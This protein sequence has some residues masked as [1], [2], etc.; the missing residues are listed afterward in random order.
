MVM[1]NGCLCHHFPLLLGEGLEARS[2]RGELLRAF[3]R[4]LQEQ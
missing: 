2:Q 1:G 4:V 3:Q